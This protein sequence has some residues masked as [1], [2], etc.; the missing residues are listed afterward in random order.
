MRNGSGADKA[1]ASSLRKHY[2]EEEDR[3]LICKLNELGMDN[4]STYDQLKVFIRQDPRFRFDWF[5]RART[6]N[7]LQRRFAKNVAIRPQTWFSITP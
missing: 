7:E 1:K 4:E 3:F 6:A 5:F 2:S